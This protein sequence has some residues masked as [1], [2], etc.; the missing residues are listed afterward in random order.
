M[1]EWSTFWDQAKGGVL[2]SF[3]L[4]TAI[5][6]SSL[7]PLLSDRPCRGQSKEDCETKL[8][9]YEKRALSKEVYKASAHFRND[10]PWEPG[11]TFKRV[12]ALAASDDARKVREF[13]GQ[14]RPITAFLGN[15]AGQILDPI[16]FMPNRDG[17]ESLRASV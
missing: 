9:Q 6:E 11:M 3:G 15:V 1:S 10:V 8:A 17:S 2:E 16:N 4:G 14:K 13:Y 7:P 5:R 12:A